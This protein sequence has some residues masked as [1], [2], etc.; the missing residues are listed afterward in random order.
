MKNLEPFLQVPIEHPS[1]IFAVVMALML[2]APLTAQKLR[3]PGIVGLLIAGAI[4][5]PNA[6]GLFE[7]DATFRLLGQVGLVYIMFIAGLEIDINRFLKYRNHSLVF[8]VITFMIPQTLGTLA[9]IYL[10][11]MDF[12]VA[13][14]L[15]SMFASHTL[16]AYPVISRLGLSKNV[17]VTTA[18]GGTIITDTAALIVLAIVLGA[19][20]GDLDAAFWSTLIIGLTVY[21]V[22]VFWSI[23]KIGRWF[24]RR[25]SSE[26]VLEFVFVIAVVFLAAVLSEVAGVK[27]IIGAFMAGLALNRLIP[28]SSTLMNRIEFVG[29][30]LFI[31]FFLV[32]VGMLVD[33]SVLID[34]EMLGAAFDEY[35]M[36]LFTDMALLR[37]TFAA[38]IVAGTMITCVFAGKFLAAKAG[39]KVLGQSSDEGM[40][41][42]GL[43]LSQ[44]AA[45]LAVVLVAYDE[46]I[47]DEAVLN[48]TILMIAA[49]CFVAPMIA[50]KYGRKMALKEQEDTG[51]LAEAPQRFL[52]PMAYSPTSQNLIDL[53]FS[54]R[55][56][57]S[58]EPVFP[59]SVVPHDG[60]TSAQIADAEQMLSEAVVHGSAAEVP[61]V[62]LTRVDHNPA[63]GIARAAVERRISDIVSGWKGPAEPLA[64]VFG[65]TTDQILSETEQQVM[66]CHL[67]QPIATVKRV[68]LIFPPLIEYH[69]GY[70]RA[71]Q[72][73]K[74][75]TNSIGALLT[76]LCLKD[77]MRKIRAKVDTVDPELASSFVGFSSMED[78]VTTLKKRVEEND[79]II[80]LTARRGTVPWSAE[81]E[82]LPARMSDVAEHS[83]VFLFLTD[84]ELETEEPTASPTT[85]G[86]LFHARRITAGLTADD[87]ASAVQRLLQTHFN[88][89]D[90]R[91]EG[92]LE[93][94]LTD[95]VGFTR[96]L[97]NDLLLL[98]AR[99]PAVRRTRLFVATCGEGI[100]APTEPDQSIRGIFI[101]L[102]P[103]DTSLQ[104]HLEIF[105]QITAIGSR[106]TDVD[107]LTK[108]DNKSLLLEELRRL[109][110]DSTATFPAPNQI[111][112]LQRLADID[113]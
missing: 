100:E 23:P 108:I 21:S 15:A 81:L 85:P 20:H 59:L 101:L 84:L 96:E 27:D 82:Q 109:A 98:N 65:R 62:P 1:L 10:L 17:A 18:V 95:D 111:A 79:L 106:I 48:G 69:Q 72:D 110:S 30:A 33:V 45:T 11:N 57:H 89:E 46:G 4:V 32:S 102:S 36:G 49:S 54:V 24:F 80:F 25:V 44:A 7:R 97:S 50:E 77:D 104:E 52:V 71:I 9:G 90:E 6:I 2:I 88:A 99:T 29:N 42:F 37:E 92:L 34:R 41:V 70:V 51:D 55:R 13:V 19:T 5:G 76:G 61:M 113:E 94:L 75:L 40:V 91:L 86:A 31:P 39:Q 87:E 16:L 22:L 8:G 105:T 78:M 63:S 53:T 60:D 43:T 14:L 74:R 26:G 58:E 67:T 107:A 68:I 56:H 3:L 93:Q 66:I 64:G 83:M 38:L 112:E 73:V 35:G 12:I 47:F 103:A 28:E